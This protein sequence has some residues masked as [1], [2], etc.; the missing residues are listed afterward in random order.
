MPYASCLAS[1]SVALLSDVFHSTLTKLSL[2]SGILPIGALLVQGY[3]VLQLLLSIMFCIAPW[4]SLS[5]L[6]ASWDSLSGFL[7]L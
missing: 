4:D 2:S 1:C 5:G 6:C 7:S 3:G